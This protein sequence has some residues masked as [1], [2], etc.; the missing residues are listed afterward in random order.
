MNGTGLVE[1]VVGSIRKFPS[2][3]REVAPNISDKN[4]NGPFPLYHSDLYHSNV[5]VDGSFGV[6]G[7]IDW[8]GACT[9]P[10]E[11]VEP[12]LFLSVVPP[13][14][15]DPNNYDADGQ[16]KDGDTKRRL[17]ERAEYADYVRRSEAELKTDRKLSE[18]LLD[19]DIQALAH[20]MKLYLDPGKLGL[21]CNVL[22]PFRCRS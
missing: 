4:N 20:A 22:D 3:L 8:E 17:N 10:W 14:M 19:S 6:L 5:I 9:V 13:A 1:E 7:V 21:Y 18:T 16:P 15:D 11:I 2:R 12:P